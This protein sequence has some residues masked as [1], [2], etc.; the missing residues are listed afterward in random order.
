MNTP[1]DNILS[2]RGVTNRF[3]RQT[4]HD[5]ISLDV[6]RGEILAIAGGSGTGKSVLLKTMTGLHR[7]QAGEVTLT[8]KDIMKLTPSESASIIGV[9]F[10]DGALFSALT[11]LQNIMLPMREYTRLK[12]AQQIR[13]AYIKLAL[14]GLPA[15]AADKYPSQLSGGMTRRAALARALAL[16]PLILFL[17]EPT[18]ALDPLSASSF[19]QMILDLNRSLGVTVVMATHDLDTLFT[20]CDRVAVVVEGRVIADTLPNL[21]EN[22]QPWIKEFFHGPRAQGAAVAAQHMSGE[23]HG[24]R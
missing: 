7:P 1:K 2:L 8:G 12:P 20:V 11:V 21:L 3:G 13:L 6:R 23:A 10:Q 17:D 19:D 16:D 24:K 15:D 5:N 9:L 18:S 22:K 14:A 4:V